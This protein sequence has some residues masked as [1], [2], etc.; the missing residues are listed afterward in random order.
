MLALVNCLRFRKHKLFFLVTR[1]QGFGCQ[2]D[3]PDA[4]LKQWTFIG[5]NTVYILIL[6]F[7][8]TQQTKHLGH[9]ADAIIRIDDV[10]PKYLKDLTYL[11][12]CFS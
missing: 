4:F 1:N 10:F 5:G 11:C 9:K 7:L 8:F 3:L 6:P 2:C 12:N